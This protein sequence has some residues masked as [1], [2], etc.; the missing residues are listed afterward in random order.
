MIDLHAFFSQQ[1][2]LWPLAQANYN[3]LKQALI[4]DVYLSDFERIRLVCLPAR[5]ASSSAKITA[6]GEVDRP[7]FLC[8]HRLPAEQQHLDF[9][10]CD[11]LVNPFPVFEEHFTVPSKKHQDQSLLD[12]WPSFYRL[13][14]E[15][16]QDYVVFFNGACCGASAPDHLHFQ[17]GLKHVMPLQSDAFAPK[18]LQFIKHYENCSLYALQHYHRQACLLR[19]TE[20]A[21]QEN[22][23][24]VLKLFLQAFANLCHLDDAEKHIN[25]VAWKEGS[26]YL[27][28]IFPRA[29]HR[30]QCFYSED[31]NKRMIT[32]P[33]SVEMM[34]YYIFP[35]AEDFHKADAAALKA[36]YRDVCLSQEV[37]SQ[38]FALLLIDNESK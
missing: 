33:A 27:L 6:K 19:A 35:R 18:N 5:I 17:I 16:P 2:P 22:V 20:N 36:I 25:V 30:P 32:S 10:H 4:K 26:E 11:I 9:G 28:L 38:L 14:Q 7:C 21:T 8:S 29:A 23:L 37:M 1:L 12:E 3:N 13:L 24:E 15:I 31:E 34:G